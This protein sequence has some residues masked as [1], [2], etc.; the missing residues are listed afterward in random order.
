MRLASLTGVLIMASLTVALSA[1][2]GVSQDIKD[3]GN[4]GKD[5]DADVGA[6]DQQPGGNDTVDNSDPDG[7]RP[8]PSVCIGGLD[9]NVGC[10]GDLVHGE[11]GVPD[12]YLSDLVSFRLAVPEQGM[13]S[14]GWAVVGLPANS[15]S[16][17]A[18]EAQSG[19]L[20]GLPV[21][22]RFSPVSWQLGF[23]DGVQ[24]ALHR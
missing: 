6:T 20:L 17:I 11:T 19:V 16:A 10:I 9:P 13:Q 1:A 8:E 3:V 15:V 14:N 12:V 24:R 7:S 5:D 22:I 23:G 21:T 2:A 4:L 18:P